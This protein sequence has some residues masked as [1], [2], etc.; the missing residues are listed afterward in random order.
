MM[1]S[2]V[3][4][5]AGL[6]VLAVL[7][8]ALTAAVRAPAAWVGDWLQAQGRLRLIDARGTV[9]NGSALLGLSD[10]RQVMLIP[11]RLSWNIGLAAIASG[12]V[13]AD[14]SHPALAAPLAVSL[15]AKS[16]ALKAGQAELPA[17]LL[18]ALGAPFNT[19][20]PGGA[21]GLRWTD[22]EFRGG[23]LAGNFQIDWREAQSALSTV[24][25]LGSYRLQVTGAGDTARLQLDTSSGPLRLQGSGTVKGGRVSFKGT[26]SADP[27]MRPALIGLIGV[28]GP[29]QGDQAILSIET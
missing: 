4:Y 10:G 19:V 22:V 16:V 12:R 5:G 24:A 18:V 17:A 15:T 11:G 2:G 9:W 23:G 14:V 6:A 3:R 20:R 7:A 13:T 25:P 28:L 1:R 27:D 29:R 8:I 21:L 26:A